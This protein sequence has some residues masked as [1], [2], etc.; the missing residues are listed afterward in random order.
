M[1]PGRLDTYGYEE[2]VI[3]HHAPKLRREDKLMPMQ[4]SYEK[5]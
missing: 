4:D 2:E 1:R 5:D 3:I